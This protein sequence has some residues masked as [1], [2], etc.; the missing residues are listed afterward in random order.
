MLY[1]SITD[2]HRYLSI[3]KINSTTFNL[4][5]PGLDTITIGNGQTAT[6][7][8]I[9]AYRPSY[10]DLYHTGLGAIFVNL[11]KLFPCI[12]NSFI[13]PICRRFTQDEDG[14]FKGKTIT[15]AGDGGN[16]M[17]IFSNNDKTYGFVFDSCPILNGFNGCLPNNFQIVITCF[18]PRF[19]LK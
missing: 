9:L 5:T 19:C 7:S 4:I 15:E 6:T 13:N 17:N 10:R 18:L 12:V 16:D 14:F 1:L 3:N 2:G 8:T 11:N